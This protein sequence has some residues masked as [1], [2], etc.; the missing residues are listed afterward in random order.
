MDAWNCRIDPIEPID[1][2]II[3][4]LKTHYLVKK[5]QKVNKQKKSYWLFV[6][7]ERDSRL[8]RKNEHRV[9]IEPN[10]NT[11]FSELEKSKKQNV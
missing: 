7:A 4:R 1:L 8:E 2:I 10:F 6:W 9:L 3:K 5:T 11:T